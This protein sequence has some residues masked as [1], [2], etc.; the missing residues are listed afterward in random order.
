MNS[1]R[2]GFLRKLTACTLALSIGLLASGCGQQEKSGKILVVVRGSGAQYWDYCKKGATDGG[3][4]MNYDIEFT[5]P[6]TEDD[7]ADQVAM[8]KRAVDE[9]FDALVVAPLDT[10]DVADALNEVKAAGIPIICIN[11]ENPGYK[12]DILISTNTTAG[13]AIAAREVMRLAGYDGQVGIISHV[14]DETVDNGRYDGFIQELE[15]QGMLSVGEEETT[16]EETTGENGKIRIAGD[17]MYSNAV[18]ER[19]QQQ[20]KELLDNFPDL[21]VIYATNENSSLGACKAVIEAG[22]DDK[23][24]VVGFDSSDNQI[25][26]LTHGPLGAMIVQNPYNMGYIGVRYAHLALEGEEI[27]SNIDTGV[28]CVTQ[29]NINQSN[30][31]LLLHPDTYEYPTGGTD[32]GE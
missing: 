14:A 32:D 30:I 7:H 12:Q 13:G 11:N 22:R 3:E 20:A 5:A 6:E 25:D 8:I 24:K 2:K 19:A 31:Q 4:E 26:Q 18:E 1:K 10:P 23:V 28:T 17:V 15:N 27:P 21:E 16:V 29:E 9:N